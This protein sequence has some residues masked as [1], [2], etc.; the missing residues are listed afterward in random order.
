MNFLQSKKLLLCSAL[1][2]IALGTLSYRPIISEPT[3]AN[4]LTIGIAAGYAPFISIN[5]QGEYEGF[6]I[7][8]AK[9]IADTLGKK[10]V[11]KDLGSMTPLLMALD[12]GSVDAIMWALSITHDRLK[13][14]AMIH[15]QGENTVSYPL[16]FWKQIPSSISSLADMNGMVICVEPASSQGAVLANFPA[17]NQLT[18]ERIDDALLHL[19][20]GKATAALV[21]PALGKK[22]KAAYPE[23]QIL[24]VILSPED[25][26]KGMGI[27]L[28]KH[29]LSLKKELEQ[30]IDQLKENGT[31]SSLEKKWGLL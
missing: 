8:V 15:Y 11:L 30:A 17:I 13:K 23:I 21:E 3:D 24:D 18:T 27:A 28:Q 10:L 12:Q 26:V 7:D 29:N 22:F 31:I 2:V 1:V 20:Y 16:L 4:T 14:F 9:A 5:A 19:Q 25:Q 6:D